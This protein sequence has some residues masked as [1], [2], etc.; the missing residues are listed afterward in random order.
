M[1]GWSMAAIEPRLLHEALPHVAV[2]RHV[3]GEELERRPAPEAQVLGLVD[4][5]HSAAA[6]LAQDAVAGDLRAGAEQR[7]HVTPRLPNSTSCCEHP[8]VRRRARRPLRRI[9]GERAEDGG[10]ELGRAVRPHLARIRRLLVEV[11]EPDLEHAPPA[12]RRRARQ[13]LVDDAAE[14]VDVAARASPRRRGS[15][16]A[17]GSR[18]SPSPG[19]AS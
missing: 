1:L 9:L 13:A 2:G 18:A 6:E 3:R 15:T 7:R 8:R 12:E 5:P 14:R 16:P 10:S 17:R 11:R 4:E 19:P